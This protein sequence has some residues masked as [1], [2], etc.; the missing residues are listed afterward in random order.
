MLS[1]FQDVLNV[2]LF[3]FVIAVPIAVVLYLLVSRRD[4][5]P[6][7]PSSQL[8][9]SQ[10]RNTQLPPAMPPSA[11]Q[12]VAAGQGPDAGL[13]LAARVQA[14]PSGFGPYGFAAG[15]AP[16]LG[17]AAYRSGPLRP[18]SLPPAGPVPA[19]APTTPAQPAQPALAPVAG[20]APLSTPATSPSPM[21]AAFLPPAFDTT[22]TA[23]TAWPE[24]PAAPAAWAGDAAHASTNHPAHAPGDSGPLSTLEA[25]VLRAQPP[26]VAPPA[27]PEATTTLLLVDD[28]AVA[29][30][31]LRKL[32]ESAGYPVDLAKDGL[33]ALELL[34]R[35]RYALMI[36]DLEMPQMDGVELIAAVHGSLETEDL[37][38]LA[39]TGHD[40]LQAKVH[41]CE[42]LFGIFKKPWNDR[43][44]LRRVEALVRLQT[45]GR[46]TATS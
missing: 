14:A 9:H 16:P 17:T 31:K 10:F 22:G 26:L 24:A 35:K 44:L 40:D 2:Y 3:P 27:P 12:G 37:P 25:A 29:R 1:H 13:G 41:Q 32:F 19:T 36:T 7:P 6:L 39:I 45:G 21:A 42:G 18:G 33:E 28:S 8:P 30:A 15:D 43:E 38:I 11:P 5:A 20:L 4:D 34:G 46:Q 23:D